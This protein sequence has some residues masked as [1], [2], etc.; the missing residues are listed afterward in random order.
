MQRRNCVTQEVA[1]LI[2]TEEEE[3]LRR[4]LVDEYLDPTVYAVWEFT[5]PI[6]K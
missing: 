1:Y 3:T 6:W 5:F 4:M 2:P